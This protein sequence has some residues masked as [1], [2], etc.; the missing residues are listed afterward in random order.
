M[1]NL[2]NLWMD[3][4]HLLNDSVSQYGKGQRRENQPMSDPQ[5]GGGG[6]AVQRMT[7]ST[8]SNLS[9]SGRFH[10]AE[11]SLWTDYL[12]CVDLWGIISGMVDEGIKLLS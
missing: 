1:N 3:S 10:S 2:Y 9:N 5:A 4:L 11:M 8:S 12:I 7:I 6:G